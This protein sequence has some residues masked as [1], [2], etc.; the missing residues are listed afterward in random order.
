MKAEKIADL[1]ILNVYPG[2]LKTNF[3]VNAITAD[4]QLHGKIDENQ[5]K[6]MQPDRAVSLILDA[7][8][9]KDSELILCDFKSKLAIWLRLLSPALYF[10]VMARRA[11]K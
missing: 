9:R 3:S 6:G 2:Y 10:Y 1:S 4:G 7:M 5:I 11:S 8:V